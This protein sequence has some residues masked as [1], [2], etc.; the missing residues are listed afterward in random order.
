M[1]SKKILAL[2]MTV[3]M[4]MTFVP[5]SVMADSIGW[6]GDYDEGWRYYTSETEY[7]VSAWKYIN[8]KWYY[9]D[10]DGFAY[11][12]T[13][14]TIDGKMYH[15]SKT[16]AM[17]ADK[18][19]DCGEG[20][21]NPALLERAETD[22]FYASFVAEYQGKHLWRYVGPDGAAYTG[23]KKID[24]QWYMFYPPE[25]IGGD[26]YDPNSYG[27]MFCGIYADK[28]LNIYSFDSEGIYRQNTWY[29]GFIDNRIGWWYFGS[30]GKALSGWHKINGKW[31]Y[32]YPN[33]WN[34]MHTK[35]LEVKT[36]EPDKDGY[37]D[38]V[39][40]AFRK[41]G[42]MITGWF[43]YGKV[44][45][46]DGSSL[47]VYGDSK[48]HLYREKWLLSGGKWY[49][50]DFCCRMIADAQGVEINGILYDFDENGACINP[51]S[52]TKVYGWYERKY[53]SWGKYGDTDWNYFDSEGNMVKDVRNYE[54]DGVQYKFD[55]RGVC[56]N[57]K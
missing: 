21:L 23:W 47:W 24:G 48:G 25:D 30:D 20:Q 51:D 32:F 44:Y 4:I 1:G 38:F 26:M 27:Y 12:D 19:I 49:Y 2:L 5:S 52:D 14:M 35:Y 10:Q 18:W 29:Q 55:T 8:G 53:D 22:E 7:I 15:F 56:K 57:H 42:E 39:H 31:Y 37:Y 6:Q 34:F 46:E 17:D 3:G 36:S 9:F 11:I 33:Y 41:N 43:D 28:D 16:G 50:F 13:W 54:I 45:N 40:Y